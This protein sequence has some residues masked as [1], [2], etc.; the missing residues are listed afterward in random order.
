MKDFL[1]RNLNKPMANTKI[2]KMQDTDKYLLGFHNHGEKGYYRRNPAWISGGIEKNGKI[3]WSQPELLL[4]K[5]LV[6]RGVSYSD[7]IQQEGQ[8]WITQIEKQ[9]LDVT[10]PQMSSRKNYGNNMR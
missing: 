6:V 8:F 2:W 5:D 9:K 7:L 1:G 4:Y 10:I 3:I